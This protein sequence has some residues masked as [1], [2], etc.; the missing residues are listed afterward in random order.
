[1]FVTS[2]EQDLHV[3]ELQQSSTQQLRT[4]EAELTRAEATLRRERQQIRE[5]R[6]LVWYVVCVVT[7]GPPV[8][9]GD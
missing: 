3:Q 9:A 7:R 6:Q 4:K 8:I 1:M 5:M 2:F